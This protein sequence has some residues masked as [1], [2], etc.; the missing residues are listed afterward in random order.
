MMGELHL[1]RISSDGGI[2]WTEQWCTDI[3][4]AEECKDHLCERV[5]RS[6]VKR[7]YA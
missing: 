6:S 3:E 7:I 1:Y 5:D 4:A 2:T